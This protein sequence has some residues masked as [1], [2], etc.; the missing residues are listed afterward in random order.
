MIPLTRQPA[1]QIVVQRQLFEFAITSKGSR[2][3]FQAYGDQ[4]IGAALA[5]LDS[6]GELNLLETGLLDQRGNTINPQARVDEVCPALP[7]KYKQR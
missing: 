6:E 3:K 5:H 7:S 1:P 4:F 2:R